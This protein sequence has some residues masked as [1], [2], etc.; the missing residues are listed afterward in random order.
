MYIYVHAHAHVYSSYVCTYTADNSHAIRDLSLL[1]L[2]VGPYTP[3]VMYEY[4]YTCTCI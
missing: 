2:Y 1:Y 3:T 4:V